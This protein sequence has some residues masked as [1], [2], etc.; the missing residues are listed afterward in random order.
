MDSKQIMFFT[1]IPTHCT[2]I[3]KHW[4]VLDT[5][6]PVGGDLCQGENG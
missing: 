3:K 1:A 2:L 4:D 5:S 6:K